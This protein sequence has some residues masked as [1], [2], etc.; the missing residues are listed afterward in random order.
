MEQAPLSDWKR[1]RS[2]EAYDGSKRRRVLRVATSGPSGDASQP[3]S[4]RG[5][6]VQFKLV[7]L[8]LRREGWSSKPPPPGLD[9]RY[10]YIKSGGNPK[11]EEGVDFLRGEE[12]VLRFVGPSE[13]NSCDTGDGAKALMRVLVRVLGDGWCEYWFEC[14]VWYV[15]CL[16][17]VR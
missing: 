11:G 9:N 17:C 4:S 13:D 12:A 6:L 3:F 1:Q 15:S 8:Q 7:W 2:K 5:G 16:S 10:L 14:C